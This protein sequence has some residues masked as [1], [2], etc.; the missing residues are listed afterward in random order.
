MGMFAVES[1]VKGIK[2]VMVGIVNKQVEYTPFE[3]AVK[4]LEKPHAHLLHMMEVLS[5]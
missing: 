4:H 1:L 5:S 2:G 3:K